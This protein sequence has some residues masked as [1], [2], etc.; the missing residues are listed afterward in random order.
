[1]MDSESSALL[2]I[3]GTLIFIVIF[4]IIWIFVAIWQ[5]KNGMKKLSYFT[6][7]LI[8]LS[9][10]AYLATRYAVKMTAGL[11]DIIYFMYVPL[12]VTLLILSIFLTV[13][14]KRKTQ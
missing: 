6:Y 13:C 11:A 7:S 8:L 10:I 14:L 9:P 1:M 2:A 4:P 3:Y 12:N 5:S